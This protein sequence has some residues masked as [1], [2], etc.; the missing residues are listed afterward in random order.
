M[1][2]VTDKA[3]DAMAQTLDAKAVEDDQALRLALTETGQL[4]LALDNRREG[5]EVVSKD[6]RPVLVVE[7]E[8]SEHV[9]GA[10]LDIADTPGGAQ[11]T[12][13]MPEQSPNGF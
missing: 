1:L 3:L 6:Q 11:L 2:Q 4:G 5:D 13:S 7:P 9:N 10:V 12:I 8:I